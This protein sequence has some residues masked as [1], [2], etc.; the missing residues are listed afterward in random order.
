MIRQLDIVLIALFP[1]SVIVLAVAKRSR[2]AGG[3]D[4][5]RG[6]MRL[7]WTGISA[8]IVLGILGQAMRRFALPGPPAALDS[9]ALFLLV[10]G[11]AVRWAAIVTLGRLFTVNV[12][13]EP[14]H[15]VVRAGLYRFAR[16]PSYTG[17]LLAFLGIGVYFGTWPSLV[18]LMVPVVLVVVHRVAREERALRAALGREYDE[19]CA[20][21]RRFVPGLI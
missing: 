4:L 3:A 5:D 7:M 15:R 20:T 8:G 10:V 13:I 21:T 14:G 1:V 12:S 9:I 19:Y 18:G 11:L 17:L 6:S 2:G 16:H